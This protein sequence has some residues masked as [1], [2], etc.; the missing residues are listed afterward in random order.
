MPKNIRSANTNQYY[1]P[2]VTVWYL[3]SKYS[4]SFLNYACD[5]YSIADE[6]VLETLRNFV[7]KSNSNNSN[8]QSGSSYAWEYASWPTT[9]V[10]STLKL[11]STKQ[12]NKNSLPS[13]N[14]CCFSSE[15]NNSC[16]PFSGFLLQH[17]ANNQNYLGANEICFFFFWGG[18][19]RGKLLPVPTTYI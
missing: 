2:S 9:I 1:K 10:L 14:S 11:L 3:F 4:L 17:L 16:W 6:G 8:S 12:W 5:L 13:I 18:G 19:R 15:E 7:A